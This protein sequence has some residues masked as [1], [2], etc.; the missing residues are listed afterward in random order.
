MPPMCSRPRP[1]ISNC[2]P[3]IS[4]TSAAGLGSGPKISSTTRPPPLFKPLSL[5]QRGGGSIRSVVV[6]R[7]PIL[8]M[9]SANSFTFSV[10]VAYPALAAERTMAL[11]GRPTRPRSVLFWASCA[12]ALA[13]L[14]LA[15]CASTP[16]PRP[17]ATTVSDLVAPPALPQLDPALLQSPSDAFTLGPGDKLEI[18]FIGDLT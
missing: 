17:P 6:I 12:S 9:K 16:P 11:R 8:P 2:S 1:P 4:F 3:G 14:V 10:Q 5:P 7:K 18:E 13:A 15:G